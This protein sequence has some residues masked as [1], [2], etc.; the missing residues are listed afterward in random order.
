MARNSGYWMTTA[1]KLRSAS[2]NSA[3][4][5][6]TCVS[7]LL[8]RLQLL[9]CRLCSKERFTKRG[10]SGAPTSASNARSSSTTAA[11]TCSSSGSEPEAR[12][13]TQRATPAPHRQSCCGC[14]NAVM[15]R[16][17]QQTVSKGLPKWLRFR[18]YLTPHHH[19]LHYAATALLY[20]TRHDI[21]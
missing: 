11:T 7:N 10:R 8:A 12:R 5:P 1:C 14:C 13:P 16:L 17:L 18:N 21:P 15:L 19:A 4:A 3:L 20:T 6:A 2:V 9:A